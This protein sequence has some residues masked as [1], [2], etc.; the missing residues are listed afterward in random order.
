MNRVVL[1]LA[2]LA[3]AS[4]PLAAQ[5]LPFHTQSA[6]T[7]AFEERGLRTFSMIQRRGDVTVSV[8]PLVV[9]PF[10]PHQRVT[11]FVSLPIVYKRMTGS[12]EAGSVS[13]SNAGFG[14]ATFSV[15]W[16][17]Y[18]RDRF[19]GTTRVAVI[20]SG[21]LPTGST[22]ATFDDGGLAPPPLQLGTGAVSGGITFVGTLVRDR[23]GLNADVS[24]ARHAPNDGFRF[25][26]TTRY[27][28]SIGFRVPAYIEN[29]RTRTLQI[30][31]EWNGS[32]AGRNNE[33]GNAMPNSGGHLAYLSPGLQWVLFPQLLIEGSVQIPAI[34]SFNGIQPDVSVR[35]ALGL[36]YLFF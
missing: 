12:T 10:A 16:A 3:G 9:L 2:V 26:S 1:L 7:T 22:G 13:Y 35:A 17:F 8:S 5:G 24:H 33:A 30:Y 18:G 31:L 32:I 15:K 14:D 21:G 25:G 28:V 19:R 27:D 4:R 20:L 29:I 34:Q 11:T 36:R 23:W 6:L